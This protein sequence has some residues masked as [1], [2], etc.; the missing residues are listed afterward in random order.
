LARGV[1]L[2]PNV[3]AVE[4]GGGPTQGGR[5]A[6]LSGRTYRGARAARDRAATS[7]PAEAAQVAVPGMAAAVLP[8]MAAAAVLTF[9]RP[10]SSESFPRRISRHHGP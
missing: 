1:R 8:G 9:A 4:A 5:L 3:V 10:P 7:C 2:S 6:T